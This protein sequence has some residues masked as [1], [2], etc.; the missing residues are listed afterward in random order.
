MEYLVMKTIAIIPAR[1]GSKRLPGKNIMDFQGKPMITWTIEAAL[2]SNCFD[3]VLVST[4]DRNIAT[5]SQDYGAEVPF[6]RKEYNDD[7][8]AVSLATCYALE[9]AEIY[10]SETY[11]FVI[12]LMANCPLRTANDIK[13]SFNHFLNNSNFAQISCFRFGFTNPWWAAQLDELGSPKYLFPEAKSQRSQDLPSLYCPSGAIWI[14]SA[15]Q[16]KD[17]STFYVRDHKY[18]PLSW[19]SAVDIDDEEDLAM[20]RACYL[21]RSELF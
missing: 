21:M 17:M 5:V 13:V 18:F 10:W 16:L 19:M 7:I 6:L 2:E 9:Q 8:S 4:D 11:D 1:G 12:Q 3:R 15:D 20:A 14:I